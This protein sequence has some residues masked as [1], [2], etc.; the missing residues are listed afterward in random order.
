MAALFLIVS[1]T[2]F[3]GLGNLAHQ[4]KVKL[5]VKC[6]GVILDYLQTILEIRLLIKT[7]FFPNCQGNTVLHRAGW[8]C[9]TFISS[10]FVYFNVRF[11][12]I[13]K[14]VIGNL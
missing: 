14:K 13:T 7:A 4:T 8:K 10:S 2:L 11:S 5:E 3:N 6:L 1:I 12:G 9:H